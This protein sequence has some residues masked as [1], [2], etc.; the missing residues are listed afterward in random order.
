M[1]VTI[2]DGVPIAF[3]TAGAGYPLVVL[4]GFFGDRTSGRSAGYVEALAG[5]FR[6]ILIDARGHGDSGAPE[7]AA[8]YEPGRQVQDVLA[9][10]DALG[11]SQAVA[12][13]A[14][15]GGITGLQL[16]ARHPRRLT[17]LIAGAAHADRSMADPVE[18]EREADLLRTN[19]TA[20]LIAALERQGPVPGW[21]RAAMRSADRRALAALTVALARRESILDTLDGTDVPVL[22]LAGDRDSQLAAIRRTADHLP[23]ATLIELPDCR[24]LDT[25][26]RADLALPLVL[27]FMTNHTGGP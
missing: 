6:L 14:S 8:S 3:E 12:W 2:G 10:L 11:I 24:H 26:I 22:L 21:L 17:A 9:V 18:A 1:Q 7:G 13:G 23:A 16:L 27:P 15:M 19:G 5:Q 20:P 25:F 4:H